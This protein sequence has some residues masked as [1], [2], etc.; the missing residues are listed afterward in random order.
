MEGWYTHPTGE[1]NTGVV[2][3]IVRSDRANALRGKM[4]ADSG[5]KGAISKGTGRVLEAGGCGDV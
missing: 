2:L 1:T 4:S 5:A 3:R